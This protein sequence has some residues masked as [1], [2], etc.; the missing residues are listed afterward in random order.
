MPIFFDFVP[1]K[2]QGWPIWV[3]RELSDEEFVGYL[4]RV[5]ILKAVG[6]SK[7]LEGFRD[8][9]G[10]RYLVCRWCPSFHTFFF[11]IGE[12]TITPENEIG[13]AHV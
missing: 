9:K 11:S 13:R 10:V 7:N 6:I 3:D 5:R 2:I 8:A 12:L 1:G 4:R